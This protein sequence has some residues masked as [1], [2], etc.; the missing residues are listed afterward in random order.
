[1]DD[2]R[3]IRQRRPIGV[4]PRRV[5]WQ[6]DVLFNARRASFLPEVDA[7]DIDGIHQPVMVQ[8]VGRRVAQDVLAAQRV[9]L[10]SR[11]A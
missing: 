3:E 2:L 10:A 6:L 9:K 7:V 4:Y 8:M 11:K 5:N 1:M